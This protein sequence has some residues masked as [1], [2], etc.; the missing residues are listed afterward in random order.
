MR[1]GF[2]EDAVRLVGPDGLLPRR[3]ERPLLALASHPRLAKPV[4]G[5]IEAGYR[6]SKRRRRH[7]R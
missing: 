5:A 4:F 2:S 1:G 6:V 3:L 7:S